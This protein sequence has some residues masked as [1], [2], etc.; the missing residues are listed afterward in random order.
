[1]IFHCY[2]S[3]PEGILRWYVGMCLFSQDFCCSNAQLAGLSTIYAFYSAPLRVEHIRLWHLWT[4]WMVFV[5]WEQIN[6]SIIWDHESKIQ[7]PPTV[8]YS[9]QHQEFVTSN[10]VDVPEVSSPTYFLC[11]F[12]S[13]HHIWCFKPHFCWLKSQ[14]CCFNHVFFH[15]LLGETLICCC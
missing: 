8:T 13:K 12:G 5:F 1:M 6:Q 11:F 14:L 3:L 9:K 7:R 4:F 10:F 2:V 15:V